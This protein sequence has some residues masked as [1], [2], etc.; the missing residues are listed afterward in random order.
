LGSAR[1]PGAIGA[2]GP[3][4]FPGLPGGRPAGPK[5]R[6]RRP[7]PG[8]ATGTQKRSRRWT[9][10]SPGIAR[11]AG[12]NRTPRS[13]G[14][15]GVAGLPGPPGTPGPA[16][17]PSL[18]L[19][20]GIERGTAMCEA[21]EI[22]LSAYCV[23]GTGALH[24]RSDLRRRPRRKGCRRLRRKIEASRYPARRVGFFPGASILP[25]TIVSVL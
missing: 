15:P 18:N 10:R 17:P 7:R 22:L 14:D 24:D 2:S 1:H 13:R 3:T 12:T 6:C 9:I 5:G 8:R 20:L 25:P 4:G 19:R 16:G 23:D 11:C 21:S